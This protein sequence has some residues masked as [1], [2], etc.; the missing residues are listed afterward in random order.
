[1]RITIFINLFFALFLLASCN[2]SP[3]ANSGNASTFNNSL[4]AILYD[5]K[6]PLAKLDNEI[7]KHLMIGDKAKVVEYCEEARNILSKASNK[8]DSVSIPK[9]PRAADL[10]SGCINIIEWYRMIYADYKKIAEAKSKK[11]KT[12]ASKELET[13]SNNLKIAEEMLQ[14]LHKDFAHK[15]GARVSGD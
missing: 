13:H 3:D 15:N 12:D 8:V 5:V 2:D 4:N 9:I 11:E 10:K 1:M 14:E 7:A 6:R